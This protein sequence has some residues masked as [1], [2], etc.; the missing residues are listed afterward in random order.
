MKK[1]LIWMLNHLK[2]ILIS[3]TVVVTAAVVG[4]VML[5]S[6]NAYKEYEKKYDQNDLDIRSIAAAEPKRIDFED[7]FVEYKADGAISKTK[8]KYKNKLTAWAED[9]TV[10]TTSEETLVKGDSKLNTYIPTL[11]KGGTVSYAMTLDNKSFVDIDFVISSELKND[12][13]DSVVYGVEDLLSSVDFVINGEVM[14]DVIALEN[15]G[16]GVEWHHLVMAGFALPEG[17][18]TVAIKSKT[19]MLT[20]M[21]EIRNISFFASANISVQEKIAE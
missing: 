17:E 5:N 6:Y 7:D 3:L 12:K 1:V 10:E 16:K 14:E 19:G 21:P 9:L 8:S 2:L 4:L 18:F 11:E 13:E 15:S 20:S